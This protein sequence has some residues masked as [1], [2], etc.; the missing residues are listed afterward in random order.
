MGHDWT[1]TATGFKHISGEWE[2]V[3]EPHGSRLYRNRRFV[4]AAPLHQVVAHVE[5]TERAR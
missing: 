4:L 1:E 5:A 3:R 2:I